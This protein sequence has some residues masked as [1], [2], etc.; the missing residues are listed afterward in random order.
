M[1][2]TGWPAPAA[3]KAQHVRLM[4]EVEKY[5]N[6]LDEGRQPNT[7]ALLSFL[8]KWLEEHIRKSDLA[9]SAHPNAH[10][11]RRNWS[12]KQVLGSSEQLATRF[13]GG[14]HSSHF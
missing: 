4:A 11:V 3:H 1:D 8:Q 7:A 10:G 9:Y 12:D 2:R 14:S 13:D 6:E 5:K